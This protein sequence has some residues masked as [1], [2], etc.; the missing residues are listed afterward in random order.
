[1]PL[2]QLLKRILGLDDGKYDD[3]SAEKRRA[4]G[5]V[6]RYLVLT[7]V[8]KQGNWD[9]ATEV[10]VKGIHRLIQPFPRSDLFYELA[11]GT[12]TSRL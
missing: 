8:Q 1:M 2:E 9:A 3:W 12:Q 4:F 10:L 6:Y 5:G 11:F 7:S